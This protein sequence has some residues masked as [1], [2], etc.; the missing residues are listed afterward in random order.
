MFDML[1]LRTRIWAHQRAADFAAFWAPA[2][3]RWPLRARRIYWP[4]V[5]HNV[6][7]VAAGA[8]LLG[9]LGVALT[10]VA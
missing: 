5:A 9:M 10:L 3:P 8:A 4:A 7:I 6:Q 2:L 1:S